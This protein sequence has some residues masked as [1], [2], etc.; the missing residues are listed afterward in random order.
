MEVATNESLEL[1]IEHSYG[2]LVFK[3][4]INDYYYNVSGWFKKQT[5]L[6]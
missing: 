4:L 6:K 5:F 3:I 2:E 1:A